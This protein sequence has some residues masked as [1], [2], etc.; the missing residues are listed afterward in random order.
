MTAQYLL[1]Q[2][3]AHISS[4]PGRIQF[5]EAAHYLEPTPEADDR[6]VQLLGEPATPAP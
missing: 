5:A 3:R 2:A 4:N 6:L 1:G